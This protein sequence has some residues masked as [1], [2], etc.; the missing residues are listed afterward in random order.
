M[1][2][3]L[4]RG[5][6]EQQLRLA[7][8]EMERKTPVSTRLAVQWLERFEAMFR[9]WTAA[10]W[11]GGDLTAS[12]STMLEPDRPYDRLPD[13][14]VPGDEGYSQE[15]Q[16]A[17]YTTTAFAGFA[18]YE[19][20]LTQFINRFGGLWLL[21]DAQAGEDAAELVNRIHWHVTPLNDRDRSYLRETFSRSGGELN[22]FLKIVAADRIAMSIH[23]EWQEWAMS[24]TC[25]WDIGERRGGEHFPTF[26]HHPGIDIKCQV[27]Q[28]ITAC[29]DYLVL[30]DS[31]W[32]R[33]ADWFNLSVEP[34]PGKTAEEPTLAI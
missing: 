22:T 28:V 34:R 4:L 9:I 12:R 11:V 31:E 21:S 29:N 17:G 23:D 18:E 15:I 10:S 25:Q 8:L 2:E 27:H 24:C 26:R 13:K 20:L 7:F 5:C 19:V 6:H 32:H 30:I 1:A 14:N 16:A 3:A 33:I